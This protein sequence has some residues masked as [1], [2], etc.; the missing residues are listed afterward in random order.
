MVACSGLEMRLGD[1]RPHSLLL[2]PW[3]PLA[4]R[5]VRWALTRWKRKARI[6]SAQGAWARLVAWQRRYLLRKLVLTAHWRRVAL[7]LEKWRRVI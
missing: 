3:G 1:M 6:V 2:T 5:R 7:A 4:R